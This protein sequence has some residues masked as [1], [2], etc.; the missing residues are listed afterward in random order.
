[1]GDR[2]LTARSPDV[3]ASRFKPVSYHDRRLNYAGVYGCR[4][5]SGLDRSNVVAVT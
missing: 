1:M 2:A 4:L 5:T 3:L